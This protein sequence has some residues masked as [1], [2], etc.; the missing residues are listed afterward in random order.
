MS[1]GLARF[2]DRDVVA[3]AHVYVMKTKNGR[4]SRSPTILQ[5][6]RHVS[7]FNS[8]FLT[9]LKLVT[10]ITSMCLNQS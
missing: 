4:V 7:V 3:F 6:L 2:L 10:S 9:K 8:V 5:R 1:R